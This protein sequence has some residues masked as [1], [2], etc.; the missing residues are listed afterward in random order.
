MDKVLIQEY[1]PKY[2]ESCIDLL[3]KT[4]PGTSDEKTF[5]YRFEERGT[6]PL[7][8][9][10]VD[11]EDVVSFNSWIP[12][13]FRYKGKEV[14][15]FQSGES[16]TC[17]NH[18]RK[19]IFGK[20]LRYADRIVL[21]KEVDFFFGFPGPMSYSVFFKSGYRPISTLYFR[22]NLIN[23]IRKKEK[24][25]NT[26]VEPCFGEYLYQDERL[27]PVFDQEYFSWRYLRNPKKYN[28]VEYRNG[29]NKALFIL[30]KKKWKCIAELVL[31]DCQFNNYNPSFIQDA[32][33]YIEK[34]YAREVI[35]LRTY[36]NENSDRGMALRNTFKMKVKKGYDVFVAK[37][38]SD[39]VDKNI[40][41]NI[42]NWDIMP[43][44]VDDL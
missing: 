40:L 34:K 30:R 24:I 32:F 11:G 26:D 33:S 19:G 43:H 3:R 41:Y 18:R 25:S 38:V 17:V 6:P 35:L 27:T 21:D 7:I 5:T 9:I 22:L 44:C 28:I 8:I 12:W 16:A 23:P 14:V 2:R 10:A 31:L 1:E 39:K 29:S 13:K 15:G 42:N 37:P 20:I 4:F 36:F